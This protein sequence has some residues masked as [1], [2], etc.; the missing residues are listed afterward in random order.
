MFHPIILLLGIYTKL[1]NLKYRQSFMYQYV[2]QM[3]IIEKNEL[4]LKFP[5]IGN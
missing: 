2:Y 4:N 3:I 5:T 1:I